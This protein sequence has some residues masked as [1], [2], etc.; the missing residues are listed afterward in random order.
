MKTY[1]VVIANEY[2]VE[3][4]DQYDAEVGAIDLFDFGDSDIT[5]E[6]IE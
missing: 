2:V 1:K 5:F 3:A 4:E 6:E